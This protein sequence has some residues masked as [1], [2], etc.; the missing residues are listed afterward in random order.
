MSI[1]GVIL[2]SLAVLL[3]II[4]VLVGVRYGIYLQHYNKKLRDIFAN[5]IAKEVRDGK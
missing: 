4:D 2:V 3:P 1:W 5:K